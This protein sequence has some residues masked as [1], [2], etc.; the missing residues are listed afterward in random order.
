MFGILCVALLCAYYAAICGFRVHLLLIN[1]IIDW[2]ID[3]LID[4]L[5][6]YVAPVGGRSIA[7]S[8]SVCLSV[9]MSVRLLIWK[10]VRRFPNFTKISVHVIYCGPW[11]GPLL[12]AM[13]YIMYF[14]F[15]IWRHMFTHGANGPESKTT[16]MFRRV[17]QMAPRERSCCLRLQVCWLIGYFL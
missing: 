2:F 14:R 9:F 1:W 15:C 11:L 17:R 10:T 16:R 12:I 3:R 6:D 13:Q 5:I 4:W 7:S 8:V